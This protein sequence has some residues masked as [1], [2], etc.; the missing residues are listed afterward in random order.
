MSPISLRDSVI[1]WLLAS[2]P[3]IRWQVLRD[4]MV[5]SD[6]VVAG[7]RSRVASEWGSAP[8]V[9]PGWI[10]TTDTLLLLRDP[11]MD[12]TSEQAWRAVDL[13]RDNST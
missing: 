4:L 11:E 9:C 7:E 8:Y 13:V 6:E 2:A 12:P 10:S 5:E 1:H 3:S